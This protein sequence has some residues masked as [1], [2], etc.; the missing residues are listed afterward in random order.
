[1]TC[2]MHNISRDRNID[3]HLQPIANVLLINAR[4]IE[5]TGLL[6][7][8][9]GIAIFFYN[10][11]LNK[12]FKIFEECTGEIIDEIHEKLK[13]DILMKSKQV[14]YVLKWLR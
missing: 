5:R 8:K 11:S 4:F 6:C 3:N 10:Y 12:G 2:P 9:I 14:H 7:S 1:M 13:E